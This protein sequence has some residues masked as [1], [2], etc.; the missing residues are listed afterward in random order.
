MRYLRLID[1]VLCQCFIA[2]MSIAIYLFIQSD[3]RLSVLES[4][5]RQTSSSYGMTAPYDY[6]HCS[7]VMML[8]YILCLDVVAVLLFS[9]PAVWFAKK[10]RREAQSLNTGLQESMYRVMLGALIMSVK[11]IPA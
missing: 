5:G 9:L 3:Q 10:V 11:C 2:H 4:S 1:T 7:I 8:I 6:Y